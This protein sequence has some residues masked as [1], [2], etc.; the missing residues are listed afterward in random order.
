MRTTRLA[1]VGIS[2]LLSV[3]VPV[4]ADTIK[5][6]VRTFIPA[7]HPSLA[8]YMLPVPGSAGKSM[9]PEAPVGQCFGT[10]DRGFS[11]APSASSRY[12]GVISID[13][14]TLDVSLEPILG[15]TREYEC[16]TGK[17]LCEKTSGAGGFRLGDVQ[18]S[19]S[20]LTVRYRGEASNP[21]LPVAP[22]IEFEGTV[23]VDRIQ[24]TVRVD[25]L[26]DVFPAF[27][28]LLVKPNGTV[29]PLFTANP[30]EKAT[31][32]NLLTSSAS[33]KVGS[34]VQKY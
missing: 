11:A 33:R 14:T 15:V 26:V 20:A 31:P 24:R 21:C 30:A 7:T 28:A 5:V 22:D 25:G 13:T 3:S 19:Q 6:I 34:G 32:I 8:N 29:V 2:I 9:L 12:G 1:G 27:E 4:Q 18:K 16:K 10:D 17:L 23:T